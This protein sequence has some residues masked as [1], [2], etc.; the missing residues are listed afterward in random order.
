MYDS[1]SYCSPFS[2]QSSS[3][4]IKISLRAQQNSQGGRFLCKIQASGYS[5][6]GQQ[7]PSPIPPPPPPQQNSCD[8]G[9][10]KTVIYFFYLI[11][12]SRSSL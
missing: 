7:Q 10:R 12:L 5:A 6:P 3:N 4:S 11:V 9:R 8:C 2:G 1:K